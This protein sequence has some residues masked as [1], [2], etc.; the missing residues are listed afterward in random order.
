MLKSLGALLLVANAGAA[1]AQASSLKPASPA[2]IQSGLSAC[3][4]AAAPGAAAGAALAEAG[5]QKGIVRDG[6]GKA[7]ASPV[8]VY[9]RKD[10][11]LMLMT[12]PAGRAPAC[13]VLA[14]IERPEVAKSVAEAISAEL[15]IQ[16]KRDKDNDLY[17]FVGGTV[18]GLSPTGD[19][20][21]PSLRIA[22]MQSAEKK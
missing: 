22:V 12:S 13:V 11:N 17:W 5:W 8:G 10:S 15:K 6:K 2:D 18:I 9:G 14:R 1:L 21:K 20:D 19:P 3:R 16:P 7:I 4:A